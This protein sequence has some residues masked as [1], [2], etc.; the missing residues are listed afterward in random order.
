MPGRLKIVDDGED[1][2]KDVRFSVWN[3]LGVKRHGR[4]CPHPKF[5]AAGK[6]SENLV[7]KFSSKT[8]K[9]VVQNHILWKFNAK[10]EIVSTLLEI[11]GGGSESGETSRLWT[12][13]SDIQGGP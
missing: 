10:I 6:L 7:R 11:C 4:N 5:W 12:K 9:F 1:E 8:A 2:G 3:V 13:H